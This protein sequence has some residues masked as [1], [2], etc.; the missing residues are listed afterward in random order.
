M[1][2]FLSS[3]KLLLSSF[4]GSLLKLLGRMGVA[5]LKDEFDIG[6]WLLWLH[7]SAAPN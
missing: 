4:L 7:T 2:A 5:R 3:P 1:P 6:E